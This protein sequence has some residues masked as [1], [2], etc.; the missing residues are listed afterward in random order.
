MHRYMNLG[1]NSSVELYEIGHDYIAVTFY[2]S[3]KVY[4]Y[5]YN[6]AGKDAVEYMKKL[7]KCGS[8]LNEYINCFVKY[9]YE[10]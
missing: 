9:K 10:R 4:K 5:T 1:G 8:G 3:S 6:S 2:N 7:A